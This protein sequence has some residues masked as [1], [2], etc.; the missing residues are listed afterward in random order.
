MKLTAFL[1]G[2]TETQE[3][4]GP[5]S[6]E[7]LV[8]EGESE[9]LEFKATLR[10]DLVN[11]IVNK[12]LEDAVV[13]TI[14]A[15]AN[16]QGG[17]LLIGVGDDGDILG[18]EHDYVSLRGDRDEFELHLRNLLNKS[19]GSP[20]VTSKIK[21]GFPAPADR[22]IGQVDVHQSTKP[23]FVE[24]FDKNGQRTERFYVRSGNSSQELSPSETSAYLA[25]RFK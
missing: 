11:E 10:W 7:D 18:L 22:E 17:T 5:V 23:L 6:I 15:F 13:K 4:A 16:G 19:F 8:R 3:P 2:I 20:F 9:E 12:K 1:A 14:A 25:D 24:T 21:I